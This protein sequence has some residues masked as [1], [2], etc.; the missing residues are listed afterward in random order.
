MPW[1]F[2]PVEPHMDV[3]IGETGLA[4]YEAHNPTDRPVAGTASFNVAPF[5]TGGYFVKIACFCFELQVLEPGETV[6]MPVTFFVDPE[7][8]DDPETAGI[9]AITLSYTFHVTDLPEDYRPARP[10]EARGGELTT[11]RRDTHGPRQT[12]RLPHP[13]PSIWPLH[14]RGGAFAM[15][16]GAVN[17]MHG[18]GPWLF[19]IGFAAV[20][21]VMYGWWA[22]VVAESQQGDHT[23]VVRHRP[24]YGFIMFIMSEVMFFAAWFWA[25]SSTPSTR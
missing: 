19:L 13:A 24:A 3:R 20:L 25:S 6:L 8:V 23:P 18:S 7:I 9:P 21:Y 17:W 1:T 4:F 15:L 11:I 5:E 12:P 16:F 22:D 14:R 2:R 10:T